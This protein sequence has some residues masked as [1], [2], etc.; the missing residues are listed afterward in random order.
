MDLRQL[1]PRHRSVECTDMKCFSALVLAKDS[2][3][4]SIFEGKKS[5]GFS[6]AE[7]KAYGY[8]AEV[9]SLQNYDIDTRS[10]MEPP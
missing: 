2:D 6:D 1:L 9:H 5:T 4:K 8:P 3:G 7:E 10:Q